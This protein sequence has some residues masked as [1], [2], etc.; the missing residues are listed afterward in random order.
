MVRMFSYNKDESPFVFYK[1]LFFIKRYDIKT[2]LLDCDLFHKQFACWVFLLFFFL[3]LKYCYAYAAST[4]HVK[5]Q[6]II[7]LFAKY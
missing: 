3:H 6:T 5:K 2:L 1:M 4:M 7:R